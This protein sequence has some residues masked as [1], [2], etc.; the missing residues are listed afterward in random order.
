M[1]SQKVRRGNFPRH[2]PALA[3]LLIILVFTTFFK[4]FY[5]EIMLLIN[6]NLL[7]FCGLIPTVSL[8]ILIAACDA[9]FDLERL[10]GS[11]LAPYHLICGIPSLGPTSSSHWVLSMD[12]YN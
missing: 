6:R 12:M 7:Q 1:S 5:N 3:P 8:I 11:Y 9:W 4:L 10:L 2:P